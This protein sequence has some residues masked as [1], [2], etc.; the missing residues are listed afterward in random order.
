M[1]PVVGWTLYADRGTDV[2]VPVQSLCM[3]LSLLDQIPSL[4]KYRHAVKNESK[5]LRLPALLSSWWIDLGLLRSTEEVIKIRN[6]W[7]SPILEIITS[8]N[9]TTK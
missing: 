9:L 5:L 7:C 3:N 4:V 1:G 2:Q 8:T 6:L